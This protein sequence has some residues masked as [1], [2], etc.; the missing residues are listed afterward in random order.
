M[1][2]PYMFVV[3]FIAAGAGTYLC[4][5]KSWNRAL[6]IKFEAVSNESKKLQVK[7]Q[8]T[9][10]N[11]LA[12]RSLMSARADNFTPHWEVSI[13]SCMTRWR[14]CGRSILPGR[15]ALFHPILVCQKSGPPS[16]TRREMS[17]VH[18]GPWVYVQGSNLEL[19]YEV[20]D[21]HSKLTRRGPSRDSTKWTPN[22]SFW[23]VR[24]N[25][26]FFLLKFWCLF[27]DNTNASKIENR[28]KNR[29]FFFFGGGVVFFPCTK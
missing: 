7:F 11:P 29:G 3:C 6:Y 15:C 16:D 2:R 22:V 24:T 20:Q 14:L 13:E 27:T 23:E 1:R 8:K 12:Q 9:D 4:E 17:A 26:C 21:K 10:R 28:K 25:F 5:Q 19:G 18:G